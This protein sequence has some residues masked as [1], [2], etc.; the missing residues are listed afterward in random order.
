[1]AEFGDL[2]RAVGEFG[3]YQKLLI[4]LLSLPLLLNP[5]QMVGQ[6][7]MV[8]DVPHHCDTSWIR[9]VGPNLTEEEQLN[10]T[11][12]R[13]AD[14]NFEQCSMFS[15][16]DWD[17]HSILAYGLN[18]TEKCSS[19]WVYPSEQ[20]PSLLTEVCTCCWRRQGHGKEGWNILGCAL[21]SQCQLGWEGVEYLGLCFGQQVPA[22]VGGGGISWPVLWSA[23]ASCGAEELWV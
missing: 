19:G 22:V 4:L 20:P 15:P 17:L 3:L 5:F 12:P 23:S 10:L 13:G 6:V 18:H 2:L 7:F 21:V 16:V 8:V 1:M 11:L 9:A 14:G